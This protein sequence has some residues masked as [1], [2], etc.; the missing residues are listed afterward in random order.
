MS[1]PASQTERD[2]LDLT[3]ERREVGILSFFLSAD[4]PKPLICCAFELVTMESLECSSLQSFPVVGMGDLY[5]SFRTLPHILSIEIRDS[6]L[7]NDIVRVRAGCHH[8]GTR[9]EK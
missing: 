5:Q 6:I 3:S 7:C 1:R 2:I 4:D 8:A 9:L